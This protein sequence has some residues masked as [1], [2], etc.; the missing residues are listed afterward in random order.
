MG[1]ID[2]AT[3]LV[4]SGCCPL[5]S[6]VSL[7]FTDAGALVSEATAEDILVVTGGVPATVGAG[8]VAEGDAGW[9]TV[10]G[11]CTSS[12]EG[13][14]FTEMGGTLDTAAA[15]SAMA[16]VSAARD[17]WLTCELEAAGAGSGAKSESAP[18]ALMATKAI[19][20]KN[21]GNARDFV[22]GEEMFLIM[23]VVRDESREA[24]NRDAWR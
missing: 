12:A 14:G 18:C 11:F 21:P 16:A 15:A 7:A 24:I 22:I 13:S 3:V 5:V 4:T 23:R 6:L 8:A 2:G 1:L 10:G 20:S 17:G 9:G 19:M